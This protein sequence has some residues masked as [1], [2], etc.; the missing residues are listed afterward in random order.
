MV[1]R[2]RTV[3]V[4]DG[5]NPVAVPAAVIATRRTSTV[6]RL[7]QVGPGRF[8]P[9]TIRHIRSVV[10]PVADRILAPLQPDD[11]YGYN[12]SILNLEAASAWDTNVEISG[13]SM[14]M[15]VLLAILS[16]SL[17]LNMPEDTVVSGHIASI[18]GDM[19]VV[20]HLSEKV[21]ALD[22][23]AMIRWFVYASGEGDESL[24]IIAPKESARLILA[25]RNARDSLCCV[26]VGNVEEL[27]KTILTPD[28]SPPA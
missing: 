4:L 12:L 19:G 7:R 14:D 23:D 5:G 3:L 24:Q 28:Y 15:S 1:G 18:D 13:F 26:S 16:V 17:G 21:G 25:I 20:C 8:D 9:K 11:K 27:L 2:V 10:L 6:Q 22:R